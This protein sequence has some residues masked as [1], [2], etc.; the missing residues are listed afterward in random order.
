MIRLQTVLCLR[1]FIEI[2]L[3]DVYFPYPLH[4]IVASMFSFFLSLF[5][6]GFAYT[7]LSFEEENTKNNEGK[8]PIF[9]YFNVGAS[10]ASNGDI[11]NATGTQSLFVSLLVNL[12]STH[13]ILPILMCIN[14]YKHYHDPQIYTGLGITTITPP[15][16]KS[17]WN[18]NPAPPYY[19][20]THFIFFYFI[21]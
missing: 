4:F 8:N 14:I 11:T 13:Q 1:L 18:T 19:Y 10:N 7:D 17:I 5:C 20:T 21:L 16:I 6:F 3:D 12:L 9:I 15:S 2:V